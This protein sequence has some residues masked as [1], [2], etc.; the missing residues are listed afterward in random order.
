VAVRTTLRFEQFKSCAVAVDLGHKFAELPD[1]T[2]T[3]QPAD[4][5][6]RGLETVRKTI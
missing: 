1:R 3:D 6:G 5:L 4:V 2:P